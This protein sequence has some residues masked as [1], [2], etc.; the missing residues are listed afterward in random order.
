M[1]QSFH[2]QKASFPGLFILILFSNNF[3]LDTTIDWRELPYLR[4]WQAAGLV[5]ILY[6]FI[7]LVAAI[8]FLASVRTRFYSI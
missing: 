4:S 6:Y 3:F 5:K 1:Y 8:T 2:H 7:I